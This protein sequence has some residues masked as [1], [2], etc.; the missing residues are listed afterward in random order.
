MSAQNFI[1]LECSLLSFSKGQCLDKIAKQG[2]LVFSV[3]QQQLVN[4]ADS[5][6]QTFCNLNYK[7]Y[8]FSV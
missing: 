5:V 7:H 8:I 4:S 3:N 1:I 2:N 6:S